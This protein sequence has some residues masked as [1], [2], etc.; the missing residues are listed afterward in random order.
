MS[1]MQSLLYTGKH[2]HTYICSLPTF[3]AE[4][5]NSNSPSPFSI[6]WF[7]LNTCTYSSQRSG[8]LLRLCILKIILLFT[9]ML[10]LQYLAPI[11]AKSYTFPNL[12]LLMEFSYQSFLIKINL[13]I[14]ILQNLSFIHLHYI[15]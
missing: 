3:R 12:L 13:K 14:L 1:S 7:K 10:F 11:S 8:Q 9:F 4:I 2:T 15:N 6:V 5:E